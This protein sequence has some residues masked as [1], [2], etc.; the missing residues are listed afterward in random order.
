MKIRR[1]YSQPFFREPKRHRLRNSLIA[2]ILGL[3]LGLAIV[4][5]WQTVE[6][7]VDSLIGIPATPTPL[8]SQLATRAALLAQGGDFSAADALLAE[9]VAERPENIAYL[10]EYGK[11]Q[12]E[13]GRYDEAYALGQTIVDLEARDVRGF[14]LKANAL[15]WNGDASVAIPI[16]L[17]GLELDP[18]FTSLYATL[19]RGYIDTQRW[20]DGLD[21]G[22]RGLAINS[23]DAELV[24]AYAYALQSVGAY[25]EA[26]EQLEHAIELRPGY[27]PPHFELAALYLSRDNDQRAID[28]YDRILALDS[29]NARAM[30]RQ[31]LAFRKVGQFARALGFCEDS[32]AND[33]SDAEAL[34]HLSLLYYRERRFAESRDLFQQCLD[35]DDGVYDLSCRFR[36]GL[37]HYYT[38]NCTTGW[39]LLQESLVIAEA[40]AGFGDTVNNIQQGLTA[41]N[42]DPA[43]IDAAAATVSFQD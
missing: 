11:V 20:A 19:S 18:R 13:L 37:S 42:N 26:A 30:L 3:L 14:A 43:C 1:D 16:G 25:D 29:R 40:R 21:M 36:L 24:R 32:V 17:S 28:L 4:S 8:P 35:H 9:A 12:I 38:G 41:I 5:R 27:L 7:V 6:Q 31:C 39:A 34:F 15:V 10:Y 2:A 23:S 22:E 33:P